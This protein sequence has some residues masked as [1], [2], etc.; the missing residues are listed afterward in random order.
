M[1]LPWDLRHQA[2][3]S[4]T[5]ATLPPHTFHRHNRQIIKKKKK[6][7]EQIELEN[8]LLKIPSLFLFL[9]V[10]LTNPLYTFYSHTASTIGLG[11][12]QV[13]LHKPEINFYGEFLS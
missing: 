9:V 13:S 2:A 10:L 5:L 6:G 11:L 12:S 7:P 1:R 4:I 8:S 3:A